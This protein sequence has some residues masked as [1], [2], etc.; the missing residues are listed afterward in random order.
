MSKTFRVWKIDEPLLLPPTVGDFVAEDHF[1][2]FVL[3]LVRDDIN[4]R[5]YR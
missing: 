2:H 1:A 5:D 3:T 4:L